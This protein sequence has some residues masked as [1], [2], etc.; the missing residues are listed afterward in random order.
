MKTL[1]LKAL[2]DRSI[3]IKGCGLNQVLEVISFDKIPGTI[4]I[5][6]KQNNQS[7]RIYCIYDDYE[8]AWVFATANAKTIE[9]T[10]ALENIME[11]GWDDKNN[12]YLDLTIADDS[13]IE[14]E[15][16][17]SES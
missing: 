4:F 11:Y 1:S 12:T 10:D 8:N 2:N 16:Q 13:V 7:I 5:Y 17:F 3:L 6:S 14:L 15:G 9:K